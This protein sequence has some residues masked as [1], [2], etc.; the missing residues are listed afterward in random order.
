VE[1]QVRYFI[2]CFTSILYEALPF[3]VLG[4]VISG[5]LEELVPQELIAKLVPRNRPL[6][7]AMSCLLGICFPMC[8]CGI[9]PVMRR[10]LRKGLPL[11]CCVAYMLAGPI[12]NVVV[13]L[14]TWV[15]FRSYPG[16]ERI[17]WLRMLGGFLVASGTAWVVELMYRRQGVSLLAPQAR[18]DAPLPRHKPDEPAPS[19]SDDVV[20]PAEEHHEEEEEAKAHGEKV[21]TWKRVSNI[22]ET[23]LHDFVDITVYLTLGALLA[24]AT[25]LMLS[26]QEVETISMNYPAVAIVTMMGLAILLCLCSEADAFV[27]ASFTT[28]Q[29]SAKLGFLVLGPM[30]DLKLYMMFT[31]VFSHR[32]IWT[33]IL[34]VVVQV[35]IYALV[36]HAIWHPSLEAAMTGAP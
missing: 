31:R 4:A 12:I 23:S 30:L 11:S 32:L 8:E 29:P 25:R 6:A 9:V 10:L 15:A 13:F 33:I 2:I 34:C 5:V 28:L 3:I 26:K 1:D 19:E 16:G 21:S 14:S 35:L 22:A 7:I 20:S 17:V 27:A 18:P 36:V 24:S